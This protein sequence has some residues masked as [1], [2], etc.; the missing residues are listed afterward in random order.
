VLSSMR[1]D[2]LLHN[3]FKLSRTEAAE[4]VKNDKVQVNHRPVS[5][6]SAV[7]KE[8]DVV[9]VRSKGRFIVGETLGT[10]KK[11]NVRVRLRK[12]V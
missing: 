4:Y 3:A 8:G 10:T 12:Y 5:K 1:I 2:T 6:P 11:G 7:L 9:S